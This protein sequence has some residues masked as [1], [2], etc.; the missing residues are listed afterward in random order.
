MRRRPFWKIRKVD[1]DWV[2]YRRTFTWTSAW[3]SVGRVSTFSD[4]VEV[5]ETGGR[6]RRDYVLASA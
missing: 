1:D 3:Y 5:V 2:V 4:A 6:V